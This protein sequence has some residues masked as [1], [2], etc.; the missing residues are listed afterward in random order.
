MNSEVKPYEPA[1]KYSSPFWRV[2]AAISA[3]HKRAAD[4]TSVSST[5]CKSK[6]ERLI[7]VSTSSLSF[8]CCIAALQQQTETADVLTVISRSAFDLQAERLITVSTSA[9]AV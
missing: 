3:S 6:A 4:S 7:T 2:I 9:V 8:C 5:A 1:R